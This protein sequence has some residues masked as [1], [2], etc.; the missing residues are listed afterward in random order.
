MSASHVR[1]L[2]VKTVVPKIVNIIGDLA[3]DI[4]AKHN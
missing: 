4:V 3:N 2:F 1:Q